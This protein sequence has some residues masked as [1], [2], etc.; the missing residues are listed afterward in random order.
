MKLVSFV[1]PFLQDRQLIWLPVCISAHKSPSEKGSL[2]GKYLFP[3]ICSPWDGERI[4]PVE[5]WHLFK[6]EAKQFWQICA[7]WSGPSKSANK[8]IGYYRMNVD[9]RPGWYFERTQDELNL[10][11]LCTC[12]WRHFFAWRGQL[13]AVWFTC[14]RFSNLRYT[15]CFN[16]CKKIRLDVGTLVLCSSS[17]CRPR[18]LSWMRRPTGD[19]EVAGSTPRRGRQHSFVGIDHE[20]FSTV[21]LSPFRWFKKGSCQFLAKECAQYWLTA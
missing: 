11:I 21:I 4:L 3:I 20:I 8:I 12:I 18:W 16:A 1:T 6:S 7:V 2:K 13:Q 17:H 10:R 14:A 5:S 19:Q 9:Q 15:L